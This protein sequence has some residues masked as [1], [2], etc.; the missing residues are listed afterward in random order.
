MSPTH[1]SLTKA[2]K[3]RFVLKQQPIFREVKRLKEGREET[4]KFLGRR[5]KIPRIRN[6]INY[7]RRF[8]LIRV[9]N[10]M[11]KSNK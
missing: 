6:K 10:E 9:K 4:R 7:K 8:I 5:S 2:G 1:G 3:M 11:G